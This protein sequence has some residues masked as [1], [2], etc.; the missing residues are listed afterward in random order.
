[1][2]VSGFWGHFYN[3]LPVNS[4]APSV[5][6][7]H[8][9]G[10]VLTASTGTWNDP[11]DDSITYSYQWERANDASGGGKLDIPG[12]TAGTY[13][14]VAED[15]GKYVRVT[16]TANDGATGTVRLSS[17]WL[18]VGLPVVSSVAPDH[19]PVAGSTPVTIAG[20]HFNGASSVTFDGTPA[21]PP[22]TVVDDTTITC[23]TPA[24]TVGPVPVAVTTPG[25]TGALNDG[26][27][28]EPEL[29]VTAI[30]PTSGRMGGHFAATPAL[31]TITGSGF[32]TSGTVTV[33]F[34]SAWGARP[35]TNVVVVD[36]TT[37]TCETPPQIAGP[38]DVTVTN[39]GPVSAGKPDAYTFT[40]S[41]G[42]IASRTTL[43]DEDLTAGDLI[44]ERRFVAGL[45]TP[46]AGPEFQ[47]ADVA[48][49]DPDRGGEGLT[50]AD[51]SQQRR[52]V[53]GLDPF[54]GAAGPW[55]H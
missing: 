14:L 18:Y 37:I 15:D 38:A 23:S 21:L 3:R 52:Y 7:T 1:M 39:P 32:A 26:Y 5:S 34:D 6:G 10:Q 27:E 2:K 46:Q 42:D 31:A 22:V 13:T 40:G 41:E 19:G 49:R 8:A 30:N 33:T 45:D 43:G 54:T 17:I 4:L 44:Q 55:N 16:V 20:S 35:A 9:V 11:D 29:Q 51:L 24:H 12:A 50:A 47:R 25:G 48:P 36:S 53:A 28:Y